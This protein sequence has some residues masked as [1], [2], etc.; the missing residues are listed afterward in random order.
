VILLLYSPDDDDE[1]PLAKRA[2]LF[3]ER[4]EWARQSNPSAAELT[5]PR[6]T[7]VPKVPVSMVNPS[8]SA[9]TPSIARD[10]VS[11]IF[12]SVLF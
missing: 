1:V 11:T 3:S 10:H 5:P 7:V 6:R 12:D 9:F 2:T 8:A 4:S